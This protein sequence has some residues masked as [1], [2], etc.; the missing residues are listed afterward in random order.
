MSTDKL[1]SDGLHSFAFI[2]RPGAVASTKPKRSAQE[3]VIP[4]DKFNA[5]ISQ[6]VISHIILKMQ[7]LACEI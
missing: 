2:I 5:K 3:P 6:V 1:A 7:G 4:K